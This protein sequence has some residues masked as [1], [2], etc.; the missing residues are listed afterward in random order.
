MTQQ[1]LES[2]VSSF[3]I[4][5]EDEYNEIFRVIFGKKDP[6]KCKIEYSRG[7]LTGK[8]GKLRFWIETE[9]GT[10]YEI[11]PQNIKETIENVVVLF[12]GN[13]EE[14]SEEFDWE[15]DS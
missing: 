4:T 2:R 11:I 9:D 1:K 3:I 7:R 6:T 14:E 8:V 10:T 12:E 15:K 13:S 5:L